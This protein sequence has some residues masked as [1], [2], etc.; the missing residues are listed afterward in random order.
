MKK[1]ILS[2][3]A[4]ALV[5]SFAVGTSAQ[6]T[7]SSEVALS[8]FNTNLTIGSTGTDV[9][10]LQT[11]LITQGHLVIP[12]GVA[13]GYFG[14][15]TK[16]A[17]AKWQASVGISPAVGYFGP[18][19]RAAINNATGGTS[20]GN[21]P[22][23]CSSTMG[24]S[25][26][27]GAKCD[28]GSTTGGSTTLSGGEA[29]LEDLSAK[30]G[31]D[32]SVDEGGTAEIAEF[33]FDV[34]DGDARINR[35]DLTFTTTNVSGN[36]TEPWNT[37]DTITIKDADGKELASEDVSDEDDWLDENT[38]FSFR[39][40]G[41]DYVVREGD[42]GTLI[43]EVE[44]QNGI[45]RASSAD[46]PWTVYI[47]TDGLRATDGEGIEQYAG[48]N[49]ETVTFDVSEEGS[50]DDL[51]VRSSN[52]DP[53]SMTLQV[54]DTDRSDWY[55]I[56]SFELDSDEDSGDIELDQLPVTFTT[57]DRVG[58]VI[59][60]LELVIDGETFDDYGAFSA[61]TATVASTTFD[62]DKD[63][64]VKGG[65]TI[66]VEVRAQFKAST[67]NYTAGTTTIAASVIGSQIEAEGADDVVVTGTA[68]GETHTLSL[69]DVTID[70][71]IWAVDNNAG[72]Y[73]DFFF[74]VSAEDE[75]FNVLTS[76]I[77]SST[78]GTATTS[79]GVLTKSSGD[80]VDTISGG[81][82]VDAGETT[83]FRIRYSVTGVNGTFAEVT[84]T[85]VAGQEVPD[86]KELSPTATRNVNS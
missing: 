50:D 18:I 71:F 16:M 37:F 30:D 41:L 28:S 7:T 3:F 58:D 26:T 4:F 9:A 43:V 64:T 61:P 1:V 21:L 10:A 73:I 27:T 57:N 38:P 32:D 56:F 54:E 25:S 65:E 17:V 69:A 42:M 8:Q 82:Q 45:D 60:D 24:F 62:I 47:G 86:N 51:S 66:T 11:I 6:T 63:Y 29:S 77:A 70:N 46:I 84:I 44:A 72:A 23:G 36:E 48:D 49:A 35:V 15:L 19:S 85:E 76:S 79:A 67:G 74:T 83:T 22:A 52:E 55:T 40:T 31:E 12:A 20:T 80:A 81:F 13:K 53:D 78:S 75:D 39:F 34:E 59:N 2:A 33:E 68:T 14:T 5:L